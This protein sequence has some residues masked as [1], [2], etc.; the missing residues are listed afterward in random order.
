M[1]TPNIAANDIGN[2]NSKEIAKLI[3]N[4]N[5]IHSNWLIK[6]CLLLLILNFL[7]YYTIGIY[8]N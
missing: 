4:D 7:F 1:N 2:G 5:P 6:N 3:P 8:S